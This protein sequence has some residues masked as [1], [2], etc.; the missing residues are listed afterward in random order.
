MKKILVFVVL[1][2]LVG[3]VAEPS[4]PEK[5]RE[6]PVA[7]VPV[8]EHEQVLPVPYLK[9]LQQR[10]DESILWGYDQEGLLVLLNGSE[11]SV[12]LEY[13]RDGKLVLIDDGEPQRFFYDNTGKLL[14]VEQGLKRL[15]FTYSSKGRLLSMEDGEK[16]TVTH[17]SKGRLSSVARDNGPSTEFVYDELNR[18]K[19]LFKNRVETVLGYDD[20]GRLT[21]FDR[22]D[23][24]LVIAYWREDLLSSLSGTMY[25]LKETVNYGPTAIT[26]VSNVEENV[27]ES[28]YPDESAARMD[29]FNTFLFCTRFRKLPV[30]FDGQ[31]WVLYH[32]YLKGNISD[33][34]LLTF[35]CKV[36]P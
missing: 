26:L 19:S 31:S 29:A 1:A 2:F 18:T 28:A 30:L 4:L 13:D 35:T 6:V 9:V 3:C 5:A 8:V 16:L 21:R 33:Y 17:D 11:K 12:V 10:G 22:D 25:G 34:L 36:L 7:E 15:L 32:E 20:D 27:F 24:H 14:S 23:D